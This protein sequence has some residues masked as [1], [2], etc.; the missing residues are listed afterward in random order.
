MYIY[1]FV[2]FNIWL[3]IKLIRNIEKYKKD[4]RAV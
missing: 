4:V 3:N 1:N 2:P